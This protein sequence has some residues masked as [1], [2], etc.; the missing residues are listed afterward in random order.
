[1]LRHNRLDYRGIELPPVASHWL[2]R[3]LRLRV[4]TVQV[5]VL[6]AL[7]ARPHFSPLR[8]PGKRP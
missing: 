4:N 3:R 8:R 1:M 2:V 7:G 6:I 5:R